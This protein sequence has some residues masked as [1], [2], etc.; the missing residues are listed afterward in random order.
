ML[1]SQSKVVVSADKTDICQL[2]IKSLKTYW[3]KSYYISCDGM[4][5]SVIVKYEN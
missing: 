1:A 3:W 5:A 2:Q 4:C